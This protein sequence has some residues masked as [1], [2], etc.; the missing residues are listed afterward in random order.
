MLLQDAVQ[1]ASQACVRAFVAAR[2]Q[3]RDL[4]RRVRFTVTPLDCLKL[5]A[6]AVHGVVTSRGHA[7]LHDLKQKK[8]AVH[9]LRPHPFD[10]FF[11]FSHLI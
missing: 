8:H 10:Q 11:F 9:K 3:F 2:L 4:E 6:D 1:V 7:E 5:A